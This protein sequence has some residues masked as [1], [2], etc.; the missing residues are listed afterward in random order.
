MTYSIAIVAHETEGKSGCWG[1]LMHNPFPTSNFGKLMYVMIY[2]LPLRERKKLW[3]QV[4]NTLQLYP[5][6]D[7]SQSCFINLLNK[8]VSAVYVHYVMY[9]IKL[10]NR[11]PKFK[12]YTLCFVKFNKKCF[13]NIFSYKCCY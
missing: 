3:T 4:S 8:Q 9:S 12:V 6:L 2:G 11:I 13:L 1:L 10:Q 5:E 7:L